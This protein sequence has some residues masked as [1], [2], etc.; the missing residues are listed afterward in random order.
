MKLQFRW[1]VALLLLAGGFGCGPEGVVGALKAHPVKGRVTVKGKPLEGA[2]VTFH[3][4][5]ES[6]MGADVVRPNGRTDADGRFILTT[7]SGGDG[8]PAGEYRV[9][10]SGISRPES[11]A[12]GGLFNDSKRAIAKTDPTGGK[13]IDPKNSGLKAAVKEGENTVPD[14]DLK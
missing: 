12:A 7:Y 5:D 13:Y 4:V 6:K 9:A 14:F 1:I 8:A 3:P 11:E 10:I 2:L